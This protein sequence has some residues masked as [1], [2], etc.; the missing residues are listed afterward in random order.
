MKKFILLF[1]LILSSCK[2]TYTPKKILLDPPP[3]GECVAS[4]FDEVK[5]DTNS[6]QN[7]F[8]VIKPINGLNNDFNEYALSFYGNND[9]LLTYQDGKIQKMKHYKHIDDAVF[10]EKGGVPTIAGPN[11]IASVYKD[12][13]YFTAE[14]NWVDENKMALLNREAAQGDGL[15]RVPISQMPGRLRLFSGKINEDKISDINLTNISWELNDFDWEGHPAISPNGK[16]IFFASTR[17]DT[18]RDVDLF[19]AEIESDGTIKNI[20]NLGNKVNT[21][22]DELSPFVSNDGKR[23]Y[24]SSMGHNSVGGYDLFYCEIRDEFWQ[25][26]DTK[27]LSEAINVGKPVNTVYD[28]LFPSSPDNPNELLYYSSNQG[29]KKNYDM[30][31]L[32]KKNRVRIELGAGRK[33]DFSLVKTDIKPEPEIKIPEPLPLP[34]EVKKDTIPA[35]KP[36]EYFVLTGEVID[37]D[38]KPIIDADV[39]VKKQGELSVQIET[40]TDATGNYELSLEKGFDYEV[41]A[42]DDNHFFES[43]YISK[44]QTE[45]A[46]K[47]EKIFIL[48]KSYDLRINFPYNV[49]NKPYKFIIDSEGKETNKTWEQELN[50]L[51]VNIKKM[52]GRIDKVILTGHTDLQGSQAYNFTLGLNRAKFVNGELIK[53]GIPADKLEVRSVGKLEPLEQIEGIDEETY[54]K[55]LRRVNFE[56]IERK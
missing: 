17:K 34:V 40:K 10:S 47:Y 42:Q 31:V 2:I 41:T 43:Y 22:C 24:F 54:F 51:T 38:E 46:D 19:F 27:F 20:K 48:A 15:V 39:K 13:V 35:E 29:G 50:D 45:K 21:F 7:S 28:E 18:Y 14:P 30:Y 23:L 6:N 1:I 5:F 26:L 9:V 56:I 4:R 49:Y 55:K 25:F 16:V 44:E 52:I 11:G 8:Y 36:K 32:H 12:R 33:A 53:R 3:P 37:N